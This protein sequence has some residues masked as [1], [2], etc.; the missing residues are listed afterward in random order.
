MGVNGGGLPAS[1]CDMPSVAEGIGPT[2]A[3]GLGGSAVTAGVAAALA[4]GAATGGGTRGHRRVEPV[5]LGT[6]GG[7][8]MKE[9][10]KGR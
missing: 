8:L 5:L 9:E 6:L 1:D 4:S 10:K 3:P 2:F 7:G